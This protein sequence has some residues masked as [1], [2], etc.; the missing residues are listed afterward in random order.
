MFLNLLMKRPKYVGQ[1]WITCSMISMYDTSYT[2]ALS[3]YNVVTIISQTDLYNPLII[4]IPCISHNIVDWIEDV[5]PIA[6]IVIIYKVQNDVRRSNFFYILHVCTFQHLKYWFI[7]LKNLMPAIYCSRSS[8]SGTSALC[9]LASV[10]T[11]QRTF[12]HQLFSPC[13]NSLNTLIHV[14]C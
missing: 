14:C 2:F 5:E 4:T 12:T 13:I 3:I 6:A 10:G 1:R 7:Q 11:S 9:Q 8:D